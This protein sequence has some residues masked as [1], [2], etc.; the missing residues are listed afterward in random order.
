MIE[1]GLCTRREGQF[2]RC[3]GALEAQV[4]LNGNVSFRCSRCERRRAGICRDCPR[5][6]EGQVGRAVRCA[7]HKRRAARRAGALWRKMW[8]ERESEKSRRAYQR[9]RAARCESERNRR[10]ARKLAV[11]RGLSR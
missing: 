7:F 8:P 5:L 9:H 11:L 4:D 10:V 1:T 2:G 6:V 3:G